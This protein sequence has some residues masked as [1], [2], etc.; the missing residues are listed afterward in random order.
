MHTTTL[1]SSH[2]SAC[3]S[4]DLPAPCSQLFRAGSRTTSRAS[5]PSTRRSTRTAWRW[6]ARA[7]TCPATPT[8]TASAA[9]E[10]RCDSNTSHSALQSELARLLVAAHPMSGM[11]YVCTPNLTLYSQAGFSKDAYLAQVAANVQLK[12]A[13][14]PHPNIWLPDSNNQDYYLLDMP[15]TLA[16]RP[17]TRAT[18][19]HTCRHAR[20]PNIFC[21]RRQVR[22]P[23][24][25]GRVHRHALRLPAHGVRQPRGVAGD[26]GR[27]G[28]PPQG[29]HPQQ[30]PV[31]HPDRH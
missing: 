11:H 7:S 28:L 15:G 1:S 13:G 24:W 20:V 6:S 22:H 2:A 17:Q 4:H 26:D 29:V 31:W 5:A 19:P 12:A 16:R 21:R 23:D 10:V 25:L 3:A 8:W 18:M 27:R 9:A 30:L 14:E